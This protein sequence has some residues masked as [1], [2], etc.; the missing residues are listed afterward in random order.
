[1]C[2]VIYFKNNRKSSCPRL[3]HL[4]L[5]WPESLHRLTLCTQHWQ[6]C[7]EVF[8]P[9]IC[10]DSNI[11][12]EMTAH[13]KEHTV[14]IKHGVTFNQSKR[15]IRVCSLHSGASTFLKTLLPI[16]M[17]AGS[18]YHRSTRWGGEKQLETVDQYGHTKVT[19]LSG[20]QFLSS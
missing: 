16:G 7:N 18:W 3:T 8:S 12:P 9:E 15:P 11:V 6:R 20:S 4:R 2:L 13:V 10:G 19:W 14:Y 1:M 17:C 5:P